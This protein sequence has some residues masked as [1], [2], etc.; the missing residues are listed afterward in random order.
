MSINPRVRAWT[1]A[2]VIPTWL[3]HRPDRNP[4]FLEKRIYQGSCGKVYPL[5]FTD[6]IAEKPVD[7]KWQA[8]W[9]ENEWLRVMILPEIGGRIHAIQ[10]KTSGYD[11][12]YRQ[13]VIK[14]ALVGLAGP[15]LS[16]GIELN[17]PQHHRPATFLPVEFEIETHAD[18]SV[19]AWCS[20]HDPM[21]RMKGMHGI[22]LH[23]ERAYLELKV[24]AYNRTPFV[25]T[26]LWWA[27]VA[28]RVHE[29][30]QS[31][32][33]PDVHCVADHARRA[34][35]GYPLAQDFYYGVNYGRRGRQGV[36]KNEVPGQ[37]I[38]GRCRSTLD[39][40][41]SMFDVPHPCGAHPSPSIPL[42]SEGRGKIV[43][44]RLPEL[45]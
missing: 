36:P 43:S 40:R 42:P 12:I 13:R 17:W 38:P 22:C 33:P 14:P 8:V 37:F 27:N 2:L 15:W 44:R 18:G 6:R 45:K 39:V 16:G 34:M 20:D 31:F 35:S 11:L 26:F 10:D 21:A 4:M 32:F 19:T 1:E 24:R 9:L 30:Y 7:R 25:Q 3:P 29:G 23:P 41:C 5:P 28:T